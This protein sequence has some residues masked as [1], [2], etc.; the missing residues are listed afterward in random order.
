LEIMLI[1]AMIKMSR[2]RNGC[3]GVLIRIKD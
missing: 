3:C 2:H 1:A